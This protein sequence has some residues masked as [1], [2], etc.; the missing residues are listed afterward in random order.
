MPTFMCADCLGVFSAM[1]ADGVSAVESSGAETV[2]IR[3]LTKYTMR[4]EKNK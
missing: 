3:K 2:R 1:G 4:T